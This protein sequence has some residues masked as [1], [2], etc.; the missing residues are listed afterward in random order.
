MLPSGTHSIKVIAENAFGAIKES[1]TVSIHV[2]QQKPKQG[3]GQQQQDDGPPPDVTNIIGALDQVGPKPQSSQ[4][5]TYVY[6]QQD[7]GTGGFSKKFDDYVKERD[8]N[9]K[10]NLANLKKKYGQKPPQ[11]GGKPQTGGQTQPPP[12][13]PQTPGQTLKDIT[14]NSDTITVVFWDHGMED[15]DIIDI[16][17]NGGLFKGGIVLKNAQQS[18]TVKLNQGNNVFGVKA[19]NEG[20]YSPNTATVKFSNVTQGQDV[21]V[22]E[23]KGGQKTD[24]NITVSK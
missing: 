6:S 14:V 1:R 24:M 4:S 20:S 13:T 18:F 3:Y 15:G 8:D 21:Q 7:D 12:T 10:Q 2:A 5:S 11:K 23:I 19:V 22:Y 9:L 16:I 17:L